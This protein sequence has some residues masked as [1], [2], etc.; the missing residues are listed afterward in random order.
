MAA[1][2]PLHADRGNGRTYTAADRPRSGQTSTHR[3]L[4]NGH[5]KLHSDLHQLDGHDPTPT[6]TK[7]K[8]ARR[9]LKFLR[10]RSGRVIR[11][12][13]RNIAGN[14]TLSRA[15]VRRL[16]RPRGAGALSGSSPARVQRSTRCTPPRSNASAKVKL[17]ATVRVRLQGVDR[18]PRPP[19]PE[20][21][22]LCCTP[23]P[24]T[25]IPSTA[26]LCGRSSPSWRL[27]T[28]VETR[29]FQR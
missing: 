15:T 28:G 16:A 4:T 26:T 3:R 10:H 21:A 27:L 11:D 6:R 18:H 9:E 2:V 20:A 22:S 24:C 5:L 7:F 19:N 29:R 12:I 25:A 8:L 1:P 13:R 14:S 17:R 23:R